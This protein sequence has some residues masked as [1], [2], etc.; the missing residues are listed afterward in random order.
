MNC[1]HEESFTQTAQLFVCGVYGNIW[2][3]VK[4][5]LTIPIRCEHSDN[6][7]YLKG[8][9][10]GCNQHSVKITNHS[11]SGTSVIQW[12]G[13]GRR[14]A[15]ARRTGGGEVT[16]A[17][18]P[19]TRRRRSSSNR[20]YLFNTLDGC[21]QTLMHQI[22]IVRMTLSMK[23]SSTQQVSKATTSFCQSNAW[24][25]KF[26]G[27]WR[28][29]RQRVRPIRRAAEGRPCRTGFLKSGWSATRT[30]SAKLT[31]NK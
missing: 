17:E 14:T 29:V 10:Y 21:I 13:G 7:L 20:W 6:C 5:P 19:N 12:G 23:L 11:K 18:Q 1:F 3:V 26:Q 4:P 24:L 15:A 30:N 22:L 16:A 8:V 31:P 27:S 2:S 28:R 9:A 25:Q